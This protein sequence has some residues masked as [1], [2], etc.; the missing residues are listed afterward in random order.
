VGGEGRIIAVDVSPDMLAIARQKIAANGWM[1]IKTIEADVENASLPPESVDGVLCF[2]THDIMSSPRALD[3]ALAALRP[4][5]RLVAAGAKLVRGV[6]GALLNP[7]TLAVSLPAITSIAGLDRP[8]TRFEE[9]LSGIQIE[10]HIWGTAYLAWAIK[11]P[12][13]SA[14][15]ACER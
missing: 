5:G 4:G 11:A 13:A 3:V 8:W 6:R 15:G 12:P 7:F 10:E 14:A 2:Y 9:R 1:N